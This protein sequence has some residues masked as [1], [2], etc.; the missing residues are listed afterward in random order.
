MRNNGILFSTDLIV[1]FIAVSTIALMIV[2]VYSGYFGAVSDN[3]K[4]FSRDREAIFFMDYLVKTSSNELPAIG[5]AFF[6]TEK[7]RVVGNLLDKEALKDYT[8]EI[9]QLELEHWVVK[10]IF[11]EYENGNKDWIF[12]GRE[13]GCVIYERFVLM[14][15]A[16]MEK[17]KIGAVFCE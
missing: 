9:G 7:K 14:N 15:G 17:A 4:A 16:V 5:A 12:G 10:G 6:D 3:V 11:L 2:F 1:A 8:K 13:E